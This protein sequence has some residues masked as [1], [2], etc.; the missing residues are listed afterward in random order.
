MYDAEIIKK[1]KHECRNTRRHSLIEL[2]LR[3]K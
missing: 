1:W 2:A 3:Q